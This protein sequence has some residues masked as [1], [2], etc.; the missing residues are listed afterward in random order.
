MPLSELKQEISRGVEFWG[1]EK[2]RQ[3]VGVMGMQHV[4]DVILIRHAYVQTV[5]RN[6]GIGGKLL[7]YLLEMADGKILVGTWK[8]AA[9]AIRFYEKFGFQSVGEEEKNRLL[10][11]YWQIPPRQ[12]ETSIVLVYKGT[13]RSLRS[14]IPIP[15]G[16]E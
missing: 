14:Q 2:D 15:A 10:A 1:C 11:A 3:L 6:Q 7:A 4:K 9:W 13:N 5:M 16:A 12:I 8:A